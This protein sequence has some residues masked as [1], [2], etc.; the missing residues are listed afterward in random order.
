M[1]SVSSASVSPFGAADDV[2]AG[3]FVATS[4]DR[5]DWRAAPITP[6]WIVA[7]RPIARF[8]PLARGHDDLGSTTLWDCTDGTFRWCFVWDETVHILEGAV[9]VT[10][11]SGDVHR[12]TAGSVAFFPAGSTA[13]WKVEGYVRK[14]AV[15]R[16]PYPG[17]LAR[18]VAL[19]RRAKLGLTALKAATADRFTPSSM[20]ARLRLGATAG[21]GLWF[22]LG[23]VFRLV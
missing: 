9:T 19:A 22:G 10:L 2:F 23:L 21:L 4:A 16:R 15:C 5:T 1:A 13:V 11:P 14:L 20:A 17:P 7:G 6:D 3:T 8:V 18:A 12:L